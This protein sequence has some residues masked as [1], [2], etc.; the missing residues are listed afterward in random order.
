LKTSQNSHSL[1]IV[2][3][4]ENLAKAGRL[5]SDEGQRRLASE[6]ERL[7]TQLLSF[8]ASNTYVN[9]PPTGIYVFGTVGTGKTLL[10]EVLIASLP[11]EKTARFHFHEFMATVHRRLFLFRQQEKKKGNLGADTVE[12]VARSFLQP[13][14][15][16]LASGVTHLPEI[17]PAGFVLVIDEFHLTDPADALLLLRILKFL[18]AYKVVLLATSNRPPSGLYENGLNRKQVLKGLDE[19]EWKVVGMEGRDW[20]THTAELRAADM[21]LGNQTKARDSTEPLPTFGQIHSSLDSLLSTLNPLSPRRTGPADVPIAIH[22]RTFII[23]EIIESDGIRAAAVPWSEIVGGFRGASDYQA[24][25][26]YLQGE[27]GPA[28]RHPPLIAVTGAPYPIR[29]TNDPGGLDLVRRFVVLL[30]VAYE[31]GVRVVVVPGNSASVTATDDLSALKSLF[32]VEDLP[33]SDPNAGLKIVVKSGGG[34]S[35]GWATTYMDGGGT[36]WSATGLE[37]ASMA[38]GGA[39][40]KD[41]A[42]SVARA[43][44]RMMEMGGWSWG[45]ARASHVEA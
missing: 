6:L 32:T 23:P 1:D 18:K 40:E 5:T 39:G 31:A 33:T 19:V 29:V 44:S 34:A 43:R 14:T 3:R 41:V 25:C 4:Y 45:Y 36:E 30:D 20:R 17:P 11:K 2:T 8:W 42:F 12:M 37:D 27:R 22:D 21:E 24:L 16:H 26:E 28:N 9:N 15:H 7:R 38:R 10:T 35:S 13:R